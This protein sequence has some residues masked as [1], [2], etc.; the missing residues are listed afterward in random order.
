MPTSAPNDLWWSAVA[1]SADGGKLVAAAKTFNALWTGGG[2]IYV[3]SNAGTNWVM[4]S[5]P[6]NHWL[7]V[8]ASADATT[9]VAIAAA[10]TSPLEPAGP[11]CISRDS[12]ITWTMT[13]A[14]SANWNCV[15]VSAN[16]NKM[17]AG[18]S[19]DANYLIVRE[20]KP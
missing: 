7:S 4:T 16:G 13:N 20:S 11:M 19:F 18:R 10:A 17:F 14:P 8:A 2:S 5:A 6:S 9:L 15:A 12:G 3:S 1:S